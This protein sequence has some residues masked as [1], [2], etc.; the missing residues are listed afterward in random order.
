MQLSETYLHLINHLKAN[1][2]ERERHSIALLLLETLELSNLSVSLTPSAV[3][4]NQQLTLLKDKLNEVKSGKP[5]QYVLG[6]TEFYSLP[7]IVNGHVLIPRNETE[8][9][10]DMIIK[11]NKIICPAILDM[12]TGSGC[13]AISLGHNIKNARVFAMDISEEAIKVAQTNSILNKTSVIF[14]H[15]DIL[16]PSSR[17]ENEVFDIIVSNPP[18]VL[19]EDVAY[20][21]NNVLN[22]EPLKA[23]MADSSDPLLFY[24]RIFEFSEKHLRTNGHIY[25]EINERLGRETEELARSYGFSNVQ[26]IRDINGKERIFKG[27]RSD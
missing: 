5:V 23:L 18:Y 2:D 11:E 6:R 3:I 12:G 21:K 24:R 9:M 14:V 25:C 4:S 8:E 15:D 7:F 13:I 17:W 26:V 27:R 19:P 22:Y 10:V 20:M 16:R 1:Y